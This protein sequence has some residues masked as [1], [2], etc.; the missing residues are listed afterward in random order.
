MLG[1][2]MPIRTLRAGRTLGAALPIAAIW[3]SQSC[4]AQTGAEMKCGA[5]HAVNDARSR[6]G[7]PPVTALWLWARR[8]RRRRGC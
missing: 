6:R 4:A 5:R 8:L 3:C 1:P 2:Q 7:E